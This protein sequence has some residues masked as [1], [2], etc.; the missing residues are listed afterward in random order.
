MGAERARPPSI[1]YDASYR[2]LRILQLFMLMIFNLPNTNWYFRDNCN[3]PNIRFV[4]CNTPKFF[5]V[6]CKP[7][8]LR[9]E[10]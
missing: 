1:P 8:N 3:A 9:M 7:P 10:H 5:I 6:I 2:W 4:Y